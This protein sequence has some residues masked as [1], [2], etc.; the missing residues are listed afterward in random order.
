[1]FQ[2]NY[3]EV[4]VPTFAECLESMSLYINYEDGTANH[5]SANVK[6]GFKALSNTGGNS[7]GNVKAV[8][9]EAAKHKTQESCYMN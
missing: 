2:S 1:L 6:Y 8:W 3:A 4:D 5:T 9:V 7:G